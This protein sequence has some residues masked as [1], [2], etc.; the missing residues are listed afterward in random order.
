MIGSVEFS[1][2]VLAHVAYVEVTT[3]RD[4]QPLQPSEAHTLWYSSV[5]ITVTTARI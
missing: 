1:C 3:P 5:P 4:V 2:T